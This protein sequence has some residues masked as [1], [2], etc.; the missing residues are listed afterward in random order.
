MA[1]FR[2]AQKILT[3]TNGSTTTKAHQAGSLASTL[4]S[5]TLFASV[6][7]TV[8]GSMVANSAYMKHKE[9]IME[10]IDLNTWIEGT[11]YRS[12]MSVD[13]FSE[14]E[15]WIS[16]VHRSGNCNMTINKEGAK[17][18]IAALIRIVNAQEE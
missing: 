16:M 13:L 17:D 3:L 2:S 11:E 18:L 8:S 15:V 10:K 9:K 1:G 12:R 4:S 6:A 7:C 5:M 14:D